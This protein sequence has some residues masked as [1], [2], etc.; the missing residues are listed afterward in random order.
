MA[1]F[2]LLGRG[3]VI[4]TFCVVEATLNLGSLKL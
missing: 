2:L 3:F 1:W 4:Y